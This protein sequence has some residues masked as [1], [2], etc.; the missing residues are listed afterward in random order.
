MNARK[1]NL[2]VLIIFIMIIINGCE[3]GFDIKGIREEAR[4][5]EEPDIIVKL[6]DG[7]EK[8]MKL[9]EYISGVI[10]G[11]MKDD[12][13]ENA[14]AAQAILARTF[15][16]R[17]L[18]ENETEV[19]SG[20]HRFAQEYKPDQITSEI[21]EA[22]EKTRGEV[23]FHNDSYIKGWFHSSAGG[24]TTSAKVGLAYEKEEPPYVK[25]VESP[26]DEAPDDV[27]N[28]QAEFNREEIETALDELGVEIGE[29]ENIEIVDKD[30]TGRVIDFN[31]IG[32]EDTETVKGANLRIELDSKK[33]KST[34]IDELV[35]EDGNYIFSGS[36]YGHGVGLSQWGAYSMALD[37]RSP[38]DIVRHYFDNIE[39]VSVYD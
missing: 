18:E 39:I 1:I 23:V 5:E 27:K 7:E 26:D 9:E 3:N 8:S 6:S 17:Y 13:P 14:Y 12:W 4:Y 11:E 32:S 16:L 28:W 10:A 25:S 20:S 29:L 24:Y 15:A 37:G 31:I 38:E 30:E 22:T 34:K 35:K 21:R 36:G 2:I 19:I 33:L